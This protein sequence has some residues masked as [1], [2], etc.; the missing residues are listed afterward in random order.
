[1]A[2]CSGLPQD[3]IPV[4]AWQTQGYGVLQ[5]AIPWC[6]FTLVIKYFLRMS[7]PGR[8]FHRHSLT[9]LPSPETKL[10]RSLGSEVEFAKTLGE[11]ALSE[12]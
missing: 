12:K 1:M 8:F 2:P 10:R 11:R 4:N 9:G 5:L 6:L 7:P 3:P